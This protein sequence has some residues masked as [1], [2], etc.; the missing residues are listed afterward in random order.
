MR[1][2]RNT[3]PVP[4]RHVSRRSLLLGTLVGAT[5]VGAVTTAGQGVLPAI[6]TVPAASGLFDPALNGQHPRIILGSRVSMAELQRRAAAPAYAGFV[7]SMLGYAT[8]RAA[9]PTLTGAGNDQQWQSVYWGLPELAMSY[10]ITGDSAYATKVRNWT[11]Y[12]ADPANFPDWGV[13]NGGSMSNAVGLIGVSLAYDWCFELFSEAERTMIRDK[14]ALQADRLIAQFS[15]T[16][17]ANDAYWKN[18]PQP[19]HRHFRIDGVVVAAAAIHGDGAADSSES[20]DY[21]LEFGR[22]QLRQVLSWISPDGSQHESITYATYGNEH[23]VR[24]VDVLESV[25]SGDLWAE[26]EIPGMGA[27]KIDVSLPKNVG[28]FSYGDTDGSLYYFNPYLWHIAS[29]YQDSQLQE[30][31]QRVYQSGPAGVSSFFYNAWNLLWHD[32]SLAAAG[33]DDRQTTRLYPDLGVLASRSDWSDT[34][35]SLHV[36]AG[37]MGGVRLNEW[38]DRL[39]PNSRYINV[40]H[41]HPDGGHFSLSFG[42]A[43]FGAYAPYGAYLTKQTNAVVAG[44]DVGQAGERAS[45]FTQPYADMRGR[46][47]IPALNAIGADTVVVADTTGLYAAPST[48]GITRARRT[49]AYVDRQAAIVLDDVTVSSARNIHSLFHSKGTVSAV[50]GGSD[51]AQTVGSS[52]VTARY[53]QSSPDAGATCTNGA[54]LLPELGTT[55]RTTVPGAS[56]ARIATA[57]VPQRTAADA[58]TLSSAASGSQFSAELARPNRL[59]TVAIATTSDGY[60][61][62][63]VAG[64]SGNGRALLVRSEGSTPVPTTLTAVDATFV[65][66]AGARVEVNGGR[67]NLRLATN[68]TTITVQVDAVTPGATPAANLTL[69]LLDP[70]AFSVTVDGELRDYYTVG[71]NGRITVNLEPTAAHTLIYDLP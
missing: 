44:S 25:G 65:E 48:S 15:N 23:L 40:A 14:L 46:A 42:G 26:P 71:S 24:A 57:L 17:I 21:R 52:T 22:S 8:A 16:G 27:F 28:Q 54:G 30:F 1:I 18:D 13:E 39:G 12:V 55:W 64:A 70:G 11:L 41:D 20:D 49:I 19:N 34:G 67:R 63:S 36:K 68:G 69:G 60:G 9:L 35:V 45:G 50:T 38:R 58:A 4:D 53:L 51:I 29:K 59:D 7:N 37:V 62:L 31:L 61:A 56:S 10:L 3:P 5:A 33:L 6:G 47:S 43:I 66:F 2:H 32:D